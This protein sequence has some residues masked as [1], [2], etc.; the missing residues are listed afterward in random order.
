MQDGVLAAVGF[1]GEKA[2]PRRLGN[3]EARRP[4]V[5][6]CFR[7]VPVITIFVCINVYTLFAVQKNVRG[8]MEQA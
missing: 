2:L 4:F 8:F 7:L 1:G 5:C 3:Q 6:L